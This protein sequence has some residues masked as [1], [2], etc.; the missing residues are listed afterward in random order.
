M[1]ILA[2]T[3]VGVSIGFGSVA[4]L[5]AEAAEAVLFVFTMTASFYGFS[6][7]LEGN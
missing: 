3:F 4:G 6:A 5:S 2:T 7:W 1:T